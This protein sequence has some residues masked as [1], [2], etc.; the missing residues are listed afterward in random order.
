MY[1]FGHLAWG[2]LQPGNLLLLLLLFG[3]AVARGR[4]R[5]LSI[6]AGALGLLLLAA[7]PV[8]ALLLRPLQMRFP[9]PLQLPQHIDGILVLGGGIDPGLSR[10]LG[11]TV[12]SG[13]GGRLAAGVALALRH[14][15]AKLALIGGEGDLFASGLP[16]A[17]ASLAFVTA[18]GIAPSRVALEEESRSTHENAVDAKALL[19]PQAGQNWLLVTSAW[20]MPRAVAAFRGAGWQVIPFPVDFAPASL[21]PN[22]SLKDGLDASTL[23]LKEWI[24]LAWYRLNGWTREL[25]PAP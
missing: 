19:H 6:G 18:E 4:W 22:F 25:Y 3:I 23:A 1:L 2:V 20:H 8:G 14:G 13:A 10:T 17:R 12:F 16:E 15:E 9:P 24:G 5:R 7:T 21:S 11:A